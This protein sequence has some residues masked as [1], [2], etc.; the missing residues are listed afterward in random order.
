MIRGS[1]EVGLSGELLFLLNVSSRSSLLNRPP[2]APSRFSVGDND[3][4]SFMPPISLLHSGIIT[5]FDILSSPENRKHFTVLF[6][7]QNAA[8]EQFIFTMILFCMAAHLNDETCHKNILC[9][10]PGCKNQGRHIFPRDPNRRKAWEKA[11]RIKNFKATKY[12]VL[13]YD[14]FVPDDYFGQSK[15]N[16]Y[17]PQAKLLKKTAVPSIFSFT[18]TKLESSSAKQR[19][20]R[21]ENKDDEAIQFYTGFETYKKFYFVY[22]TLS[23]VVH[24]INY[25]GSKVTNVSKEDQFFLTLMKLRQDKCNFELSRFFNV[26]TA[27]VSNIFISWINFIYQHWLNIL[28]QKVFFLVFKLILQLFG[29]GKVFNLF[30]RFR[31]ET[32]LCFHEDFHLCDLFCIFF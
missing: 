11:V 26:S 12:S 31:P 10:A 16:A 13:C 30:L 32:N 5:A 24:K 18:K 27:T 8:S 28:G 7:T 2:I 19:L 29:T 4:S 15:Y 17:E 14:H 20:E 6:V 23:P 3:I 1:T 25:L 22:S 21:L 9:C